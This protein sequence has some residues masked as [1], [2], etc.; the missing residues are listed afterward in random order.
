MVGADI[1]RGEG[2]LGNATLTVDF[3]NSNIDVAFSNVRDVETGTARSDFIFNDVPMRAGGF[4][5]NVGGRIEGAFYG[6][7]H[8][9]VGGIFEAR[10]TVGAFGAKR[11]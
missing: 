5:S 1:A 6:L 3:A 8:A 2:H 9:E 4:A 11:Q 7:D 10:N